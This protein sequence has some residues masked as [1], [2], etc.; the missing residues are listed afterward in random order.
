MNLLR[1]LMMLLTFNCAFRK[2]YTPDKIE[3]NWT[4]HQIGE[5]KRAC[6]NESDLNKLLES[7]MEC[8]RNC[9]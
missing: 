7:Y 6:I 3:A 8:K 9:K 5:E 4:F 1:M 2:P